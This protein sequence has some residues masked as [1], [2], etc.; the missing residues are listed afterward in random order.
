M[1]QFYRASA[2]LARNAALRNADPELAR[3]RLSGDDV[4]LLAAFLRSL[5]E[6]YE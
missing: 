3:I 5:N 1:L 2:E 4:A 6:D